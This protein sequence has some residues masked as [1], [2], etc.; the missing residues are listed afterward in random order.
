[1]GIVELVRTR[2]VLIGHWGPIYITF[3]SNDV[4]DADYDLAEANQLAFMKRFP[5]MYFLAATS[6]KISVHANAMAKR[7]GLPVLQRFARHIVGM[8]T[9]I[10]VTG[11]AGGVARAYVTAFSLLLGTNGLRVRAFA[12]VSDALT[13]FISLPDGVELP[14]DTRQAQVE[15]TAFLESFPKQR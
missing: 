3:L 13:W 6:T 7:R 8:A 5:R 4:D 1:M 2:R 11:L 15:I 10:P 14:R 12:S 9:V